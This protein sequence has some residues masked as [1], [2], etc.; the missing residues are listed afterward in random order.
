MCIGGVSVELCSC[1]EALAGIR[2]G[3]DLAIEFSDVC[4]EM[5]VS[6]QRGVETVMVGL[7]EESIAK[8]QSGPVQT[9]WMSRRGPV[10]QT[11]SEHS[12]RGIDG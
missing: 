4:P 8:E 5:L 10:L 11:F 12:K 3:R 1:V 2:A 9:G 6:G 7:T